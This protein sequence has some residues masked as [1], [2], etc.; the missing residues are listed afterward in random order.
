MRH[1]HNEHR[2]IAA[3]SGRELSDGNGV[4]CH[5]DIGLSGL[6]RL[7]AGRCGPVDSAVRNVR[8]GNG[9]ESGIQ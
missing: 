3:Q 6:W 7:A 1:D 9:A 8:S 2:R 4:V 5:D